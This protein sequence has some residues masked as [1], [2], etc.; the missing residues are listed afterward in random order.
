MYEFISFII[1]VFAILQIILFFKIWGATNNIQRIKNKLFGDYFYYPHRQ[2]TLHM[3]LSSGKEAA[4]EYLNKLM[5]DM[6]IHTLSISTKG[7]SQFK[8]IW[9][10]NLKRM[11]TIYNELGE[12]IPDKFKNLSYGNIQRW[13][14]VR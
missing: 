2:S 11:E 7:E 13:G 9:Q 1:I 6:A 14:T 4:L 3:Y 8:E 10:N 5:A 12:Q